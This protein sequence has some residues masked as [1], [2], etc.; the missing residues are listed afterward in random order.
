MGHLPGS[1]YGGTS[2]NLLQENLRHTPCLPGLLQPEPLSPQKA[3]ADPSVCKRHS[4]TQRQIWLSL[5]VV[6]GD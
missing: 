5:C 1:L 4:D 6:P 3:T 2:S